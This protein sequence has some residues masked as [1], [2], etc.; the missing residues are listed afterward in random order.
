MLILVVVC[1]FNVYRASIRPTKAYA[2]LVVDANAVLSLAVALEG[3]QPVSRRNTEIVEPHR[4]VKHPQFAL[5]DA[6]EV[7]REM[8]R[9]FALEHLCRRGALEALNHVEIITRAVITSNGIIFLVPKLHLGNTL[10]TAIPLREWIFACL[11][12]SFE[13]RQISLSSTVPEAQLRRQ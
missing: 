1:D 8:A 12:T 5:H 7:L 13:Q 10:A 3:F 11:N 4:R 2:K 6:V 9:G